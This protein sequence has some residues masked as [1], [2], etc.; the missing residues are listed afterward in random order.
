MGEVGHDDKKR[1]FGP[2]QG[3][4]AAV[5]ASN[6]K[7][8]LLDLGKPGQSRAGPLFFFDKRDNASW[9]AQFR[10]A[11]WEQQQQRTAQKHRAKAPGQGLHSP[12]ARTPHAV[13]FGSS[14]VAVSCAVAV[15]S[16]PRNRRADSASDGTAMATLCARRALQKRGT[17]PGASGRSVLEQCKAVAPTDPQAAQARSM[18]VKRLLDWRCMGP[19]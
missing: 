11:M 17:R 2:V 1:L 10:I 14:V 16:K 6:G 4:V 9:H 8:I 12:T 13:A 15:C 3:R 5:D 7:G 18:L 19:L